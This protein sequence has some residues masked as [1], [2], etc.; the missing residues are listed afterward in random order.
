MP[1]IKFCNFCDK[2]LPPHRNGRTCSDRCATAFRT[3]EA[4]AG[5]RLI[6]ALTLLRPRER[7]TSP[8]EGYPL[9]K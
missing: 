8:P 6:E 9:I 7:I 4:R 3:Y 1:H 5:R 2:P